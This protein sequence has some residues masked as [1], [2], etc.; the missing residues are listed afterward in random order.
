VAAAVDPQVLVPRRPSQLCWQQL[1]RTWRGV[2]HRPLWR[3]EGD[4]L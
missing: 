3:G 1:H 4:L 2:V